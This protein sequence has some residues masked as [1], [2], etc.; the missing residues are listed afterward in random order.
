M[1]NLSCHTD[2]VYE[3]VTSFLIRVIQIGKMSLLGWLIKHAIWAESLHILY[4]LL[5]LSF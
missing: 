1:Q 4:L 3:L 5:T 2:L